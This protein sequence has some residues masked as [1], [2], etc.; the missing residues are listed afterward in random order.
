MRRLLRSLLFVLE[1]PLT[2]GLAN[3]HSDLGLPHPLYEFQGD[4]VDFL[5]RSGK[6]ALLADDMGLGK[7]VQAV[8]ALRVLFRRGI[9]RSALVLAPPAVVTSWV[10]H[11]NLWAPELP[12]ASLQEPLGLRRRLW[13]E[14]GDYDLRVGVVGYQRFANDSEEGLPPDVDVLIVDEAQHIKNRNTQRNRSAMRQRAKLK[15]AL[16]GTPLENQVEE[17]ASILRFCDPDSI[18]GYSHTPQAI[19]RAAKPLMLRRLKSQVLQELPEV[20]AEIVPIDLSDI[21]RREYDQAFGTTVK[22]I[23][24]GEQ[25]E[26]TLR[27]HITKLKQICN[28]TPGSSAKL[29]WLQEYVQHAREAGEKVLVFSQFLGAIDMVEAALSSYGSAQFTGSTRQR[30]RDRLKEE[31]QA[32]D[33]LNVLVLQVK[34]G[35]TG[36]DLFRANHVVHFDSW[37]NPATQNQATARAHRIGQQRAVFEQTLVAVDTVEERIQ[38]LLD[39]KR[40]LFLDVVDSLSVE[41]V[42]RKL[43]RD[44]LL[45]I[46]EI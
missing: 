31:F 15:W 39:S 38:S 30:D 4:G 29:D 41:G 19:R 3:R 6:G 9:A 7:T 27:A 8:V 20:K 22:E 42:E 26:F 46:F 45:R 10:R 33:S 12:V 5:L 35:G 43:S 40:D 21:E 32:G 18:R 1:P 11:F 23:L 14:L 37:W 2:E 13:R 28:G 44:D 17:L 34:A 16:T 25:T 36:I 24:Q